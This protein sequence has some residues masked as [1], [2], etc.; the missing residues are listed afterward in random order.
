MKY[1][2]SIGQVLVRLVTTIISWLRQNETSLKSFDVQ[3][4]VLPRATFLVSNGNDTAARNFA[5]FAAIDVNP[6]KSPLETEPV[7]SDNIKIWMWKLFNKLSS[8]LTQL[9]TVVSLRSSQVVC[10]AGAY[11]GF[12]S[13]K[14][15]RV[16]Y[17]SSPQ[18]G[19]LTSGRLSADIS[20]DISEAFRSTRSRPILSKVSMKYRQS[21]CVLKTILAAAHLDRYIDRLLVDSPPTLDWYIDWCSGRATVNM[22]HLVYCHLYHSGNKLIELSRVLLVCSSPDRAVQV[23]AQV[24]VNHVVF[25]GSTLYSHSNYHSA[26]L[27]HPG[28]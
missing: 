3:I 28:V 1:R 6:D 18:D 12:H 23:W 5:H 22:I 9:I 19:M 26:F 13:I 7:A 2:P 14:Q 24:K 16:Q 8:H 11:P 15:L 21:I 20:T 17:F 27:L 25:L 10:Q 4:L